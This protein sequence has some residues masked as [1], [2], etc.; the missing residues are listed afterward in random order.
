M[1]RAAKRAAM[2]AALQQQQEVTFGADEPKRIA[3]KK[4]PAQSP[5]EPTPESPK[6]EMFSLRLRTPRGTNPVTRE[7]L[8]RAEGRTAI[9]QAFTPRGSI[10]AS[11]EHHWKALRGKYAPSAKSDAY[12]QWVEL[13]N[14]IAANEAVLRVEAEM[15][16][17]AEEQ[18]ERAEKQVAAV[19]AEVESPKY[20]ERI[21]RAKQANR[22]KG[23]LPRAPSEF[24]NQI[25]PRQRIGAGSAPPP[26]ATAPTPGAPPPGAP[27]TLVKGKSFKRGPA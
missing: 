6:H 7:P 12:R 2:L 4:R 8:K 21:A 10:H 11:A 3:T 17:A 5:R 14:T 15:L 16:K 25:D 19:Q 18:L 1:A 27:A 26:V 9:E 13:T 22:A 24:G 20:R 23:T